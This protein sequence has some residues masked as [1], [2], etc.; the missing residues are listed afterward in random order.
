M[1]ESADGSGVRHGVLWQDQ[2]WA[3]F[4]WFAT[5]I[6]VS[7]WI[8]RDVAG[9]DADAPA[10]SAERA[11]FDAGVAKAQGGRRGRRG[12]SGSPQG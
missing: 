10:G 7:D 2:F 11:R 8:G 6:Y 3:F 1:H 9:G 4:A 5:F 12:S